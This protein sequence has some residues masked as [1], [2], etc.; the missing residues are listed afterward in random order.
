MPQ[1][2]DVL[3][4]GAGPAGAWT[5][6][7]LARAGA[8]VAIV[9]GSH[10]REKPCGGGVTGR[11]LTLVR[12][13]LD[14]ETLSSVAIDSATFTHGSRTAQVTL[15]PD[16]PHVP[17]L[18]VAGRRELDGA[19][20][21]AAVQSGATLVPARATAIAAADG[22]WSVS[23]RADRY[24]A[25]WLIG[26]DGAN[27]LVRRHVLRPFSRADLSIATG[28]F[29]RGHSS[30]EIVVE[31]E[32]DPPGYLWSFPRP[33][34]LA[35]G[36]CAQANEGSSSELS[37]RVSRWIA[38]HVGQNATVE[39]YSW[40]IPSL[41][42]DSLANETPAGERWMLVGDAAGLVDPITREGIYF[43]LRSGDFAADA[44]L[45]V[46]N[47]S[48]GYVARVRTEIHGE[49][50]RAARLKARFFRPQFI[51]LLVS[52]LARSGRIRD[53]MADLVAGQ[54]TYEGLRRRLIKTF[55]WRLMFELFGS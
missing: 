33:D 40:P 55:E 16:D 11:A 28:C 34:H 25:A 39:R 26:A 14:P 15:Q 23:T 30:R 13:A 44:L 8:R 19:L 24:R 54:Q 49:L 52:A 3:I 35:I 29:V 38:A 20:L 9:D 32:D 7:R 46:S 4:V 42:V 18:V 21:A 12:P 17:A 10:P 47:V 43:A 31:F 48:T 51:D 41:G 53:V 45:G 50:M 6:Y 27:S 5:A 22:G 2:F 37:E 1:A 36:I